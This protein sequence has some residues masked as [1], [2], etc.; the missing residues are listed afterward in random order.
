MNDKISV[1]L[2]VYNVEEYLRKCINSILNQ[3]YKN[4]ELIIINDG[5]TDN[6]PSICDE[7]KNIDNRIQVIHQENK[8]LS[9]ARNVGIDLSKGKYITFIDSDD[10]IDSKYIEILYNLITEYD[11]DISI[12]HHTKIYNKTLIIKTH[13]EKEYKKEIL[14]KKE[15]Y[16]K[17]IL[18]K[19]INFMVWGKLYKKNIFSKTRFIENV[20]YEDMYIATDIIEA[21]NI[22]IKT[23]YTGYFYRQRPQSITNSLLTYKHFDL[24][25]ATD[26][27]SKFMQIHYPNL[28][29]YTNKKKY[30]SYFVIYRKTLFNKK[31]K[32]ERNLLR[33]EILKY[34]KDIFTNN[35]YSKKEKFQIFLLLFG[36]TPY[37]L[38]YKVYKK[39]NS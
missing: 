34:K 22:I 39:A 8:G 1:I 15:A 29:N 28:N 20:F 38:F 4:F 14:S 9:V 5:S 37:K 16:K 10:Y 7:Y 3:T 36:N 25:D 26:K 24:I 19:E 13:K 21:A 31:F 30:L 11:A 35:I 33:K 32:K 23:N 17:M 6:C 27:F 2:P 12:C 18:D